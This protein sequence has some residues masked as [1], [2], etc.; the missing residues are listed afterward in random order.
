MLD[1]NILVPKKAIAQTHG[2]LQ[3]PEVGMRHSGEV[4]PQKRPMKLYCTGGQSGLRVHAEAGP[5]QLDLATVSRSHKLAA[6]AR[7]IDWSEEAFNGTVEGKAS[8][9]SDQVP[10]VDCG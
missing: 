6:C 9:I 10:A 5:L 3:H 1:N 7:E 4:H 8:S 2:P